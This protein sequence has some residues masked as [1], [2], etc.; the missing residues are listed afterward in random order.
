M[1]ITI[2]VYFNGCTRVAKFICDT[3]IIITGISLKSV[4]RNYSF[5]VNGEPIE[6]SQK[7]IELK[8]GDEVRITIEKK[9]GGGVPTMILQGYNPNV[10]F[11]DEAEYWNKVA[12]EEI[13]EEYEE[14]EADE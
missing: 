5:K 1:P 3:D 8:N 13:D 12:S 2:N 11:Q 6:K 9:P 10:V 4:G 7:E 14:V